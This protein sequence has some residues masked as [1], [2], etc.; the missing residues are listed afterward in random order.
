MLCTRF[1]VNAR[2]PAVLSETAAC[3]LMRYSIRGI[4]ATNHTRFDD[5][6]VCHTTHFKILRLIYDVVY[7]IPLLL[8][9]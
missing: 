2:F 9:F 5:Y 3:R 7:N 8:Q 1:G 6:Y 4:V